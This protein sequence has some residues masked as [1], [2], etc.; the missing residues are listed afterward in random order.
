MAR[1]GNSSRQSRR[2][3]LR[4]RDLF[5]VAELPINHGTR[6]E[7]S[8]DGKWL[9]TLD[10]SCRLWE[11]GT[12]RMAKQISAQGC[13][14]SPDGSLIVVNDANDVLHLVETQSC[15]TLARLESPDSSQTGWVTFSPDSSRLVV[16]SPDGP[17][18]HIWDLRQF[19]SS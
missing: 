15:R 14:F 1:D 13:C 18:V 17:A 4:T 12:W 2:P 19:A 11:V 6:V 5:K 10:P 9:M 3:G 16:T 8:P 7:F